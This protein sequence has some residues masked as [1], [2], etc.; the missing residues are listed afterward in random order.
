MNV[1]VTGGNGFIGRHVVAA[2]A[3]AG[4]TVTEL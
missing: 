1:A 4:Y 2:L 3:A